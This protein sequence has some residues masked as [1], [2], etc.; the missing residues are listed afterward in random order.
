M[1]PPAVEAVVV[2]GHP[3]SG[4]AVGARLA[5][6]L[7][8]ALI[9]DVVVFENLQ[10]HLLPFVLLLL[11]RGV[12]LLLLL[13]SAAAQPQHQVQRAL[14]LDVVVTQSAPVL[15]LLSRKDQSLLLRRNPLFVLDFGFD[16]LDRV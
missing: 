1:A 16:V 3:D 7:D 13:L 6:P 4:P 2:S 10:R 15:Q 9:V 12:L 5:Q 8:V 11:G 14:L